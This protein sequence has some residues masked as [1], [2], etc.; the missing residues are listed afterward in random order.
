MNNSIDDQPSITKAKQVDAVCDRCELAWLGGE[1]LSI[2]RLL[3][4]NPESIRSLLA[5]ELAVLELQLR[6]KAGESAS[7]EEYRSYLGDS[8]LSGQQDQIGL[9]V[10]AS[11]PGANPRSFLRY[12]GD[13]ELIETIGSGGMGTVFRARQLSLDRIVA[14]KMIN[15]GRFASEL[16]VRRFYSEA[17]AAASLDHPNIVPV[18]E[19]GE[20]ENDH[21]YSM[22]F[23]DGQSLADRL[24]LGPMESR[25]AAELLQVVALA[26]QYAH[27]R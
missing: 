6:R 11:T 14:V 22:A 8:S 24:K 5:R 2:E 1:R 18:Y 27:E 3:A 23:V 25:Q 15:R 9:T 17:K 19:V 26:V 12:F 7:V 20:F 4:E 13:F 10:P 16:E 21:F